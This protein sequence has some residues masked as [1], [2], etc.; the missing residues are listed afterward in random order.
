MSTSSVFD[1]GV[2]DG[3][4]ELHLQHAPHVL[5]RASVVLDDERRVPGRLRHLHAVVERDGGRQ[6]AEHE[7]DAP[8]VIRRGRLRSQ[9]IDIEWRRRVD[10]AEGGGHDDRHCGARHDPN[11]LHREH[12]GDER[13]ACLLIRVLRHDGC[14]QW[15]IAA[16]A[17]TKPKPE[18]AERAHDRLGGAPKRQ[19]RRE[20]R[21]DHH[22]QRVAVDALAP[23]AITQPSKEELPAE[24]PAQGHPVHSRRH[25]RGQHARRAGRRVIV[26]QSPEQTRHGGDAKQIVS[27]GEKSHTR[28][29]DR[30]EVVPLRPRPVERA[31]HFG[32]PR[33]DRHGRSRNGTLSAPPHTIVTI[34][35]PPSPPP[36]QFPPSKPPPMH[37]I[38]SPG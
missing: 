14:R 11:P 22:H 5:R 35:S 19:P 3:I 24:R 16:D 15:I 20:G 28:D 37:T 34:L 38:T 18:K 27:V 23:Q 33:S 10:T 7:D 8:H 9:L 2:D 36:S 12:G 32:R 30:R 6:G 31:E 21:G 25:I 1:G 17:K 29:D 13:P 26:V 4:G